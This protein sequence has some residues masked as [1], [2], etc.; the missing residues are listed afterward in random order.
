MFSK[1]GFIGAGQMAKAIGLSMVRKGN[2]YLPIIS[3]I[4]RD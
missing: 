2:H 3:S 1:I 4:Q